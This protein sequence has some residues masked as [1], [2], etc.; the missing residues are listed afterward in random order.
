[1]KRIMDKMRKE[2]GYTFL[3][4]AI[5]FTVVFM[6][7]AMM[8]K[9][10]TGGMGRA[11]LQEAHSN[12]R[13]FQEAVV[14]YYGHNEVAPTTQQLYDSFLK[15]KKDLGF[16]VIP[17]ADFSMNLDRLKPKATDVMPIGDLLDVDEQEFIEMPK[18]WIIVSRETFL[19]KA[20]YIYAVDD[21]IAV[22][23]PPGKAPFDQQT[24]LKIQPT[25]AIE[26]SPMF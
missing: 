9:L 13:T 21:N 2:E 5:A 7:S 16:E 10:I 3:E 6:V 17:A 11:N 14:L 19:P 24:A 26:D 20:E 23:V 22:V 25:I 1:M 12:L 18:K 4:V 8:A 15:G